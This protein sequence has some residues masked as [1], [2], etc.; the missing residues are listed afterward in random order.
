MK[1]VLRRHFFIRDMVEEFEIVVPYVPTDDNQADFFTKPFKSVPK[2][3]DMRA[4]IMN[5]PK[6]P[7]S[8]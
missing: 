3:F 5:E 7:D 8:P 4:H 1:H 2:F 6:R